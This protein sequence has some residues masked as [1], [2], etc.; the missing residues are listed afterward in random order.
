M[1]CFDKGDI[2]VALRVLIVQALS[3]G[4]CSCVLYRKALKPVML[5]NAMKLIGIYHSYWNGLRNLK[6][7]SK[8]QTTI[9]GMLTIHNKCRNIRLHNFNR[10]D[11]WIKA[12]SVEFDIN[13]YSDSS[14]MSFV[15]LQ[16]RFNTRWEMAVK[17]LTLCINFHPGLID[18]IIY[19]KLW[20][21]VNRVS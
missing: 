4:Q 16:L 15:L 3:F 19:E 17:A 18:D 20:N 7:C 5:D 6:S 9:K 1:K 2:Y 21:N 11:V 12:F 8:L 14:S 13:G 10:I